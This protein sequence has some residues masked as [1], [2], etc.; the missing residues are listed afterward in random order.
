MRNRP[1]APASRNIRGGRVTRAGA[2]LDTGPLFCPDIA[3]LL[4]NWTRQSLKPQDIQ[5]EFTAEAGELLTEEGF[6][7]EFGARPVRR[8]LQR[9]GDNELSHMVFE[10]SL[11]RGGK[12][13]I[14]TGQVD[15]TFEV[16]KG[17][18]TLGNVQGG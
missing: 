8:P 7:P 3:Q 15:L 1:G 17:V 11:N 4:L 6:E 18:A 9:R 16:A 2:L 12:V 10:G 13:V 14:G 5:L